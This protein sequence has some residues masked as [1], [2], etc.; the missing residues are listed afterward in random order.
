MCVD[1]PSCTRWEFSKMFEEKNIWGK[2]QMGNITFTRY[3]RVQFIILTSCK[4]YK[5][6]SVTAQLIDQE[7]FQKYLRIR[8][9]RGKM[10]RAIS[11]LFNFKESHTIF[12]LAIKP[13]RCVKWFPMLYFRKTLKKFWGSNYF[14]EKTKRAISHLH[15]I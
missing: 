1:S 9:Y 13:I 7:K 10:K 12:W 8:R 2:N 15:D 3:L 14:W 5:R 4:L 11:H 6:Q